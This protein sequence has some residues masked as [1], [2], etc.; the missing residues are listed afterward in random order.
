MAEWFYRP[1][2][3][4][5][6]LDGRRIPSVTETMR[7][8]KIVDDRW[9]TERSRQKGAAIHACLAFYLKGTLNARSVDP[10]IAKQVEAGIRFLMDSGFVADA[11]E[12]PRV[13]ERYRF[14]GTADLVGHAF[15]SRAIV[16]YKSGLVIPDLDHS[17]VGLQTAGYDLL[18]GPPR[19]R[20]IAIALR[21]DGNYKLYEYTN[22]Y[23]YDR[24]LHAVDLYGAFVMKEEPL[25]L[26][27]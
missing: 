15:G 10:R 4:T 18:W 22:R 11:I 2:N 26:A 7:G 19:R 25:G 12:E 14:G 13:D 20:R 24:I 6:W 17:P 16:D 21:E 23:D 5:Y 9:F 3:H 27:A 8:L 1:D